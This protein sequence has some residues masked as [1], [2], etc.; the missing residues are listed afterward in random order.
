MSRYKVISAENKKYELAKKRDRIRKTVDGVYTF[1]MLSSILIGGLN[2]FNNIISGWIL[3]I[4]G[5]ASIPVAIFHIYIDLKGWHPVLWYNAPE[6]KRYISRQ[7]QEEDLS[8]IK[9]I[10]AFVTIFLILIS[11]VCPILGILRLLTI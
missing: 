1:F 11:V 7:M 10:S 3:I 6:F 4:L 2:Q 9:F 5:V 8:K